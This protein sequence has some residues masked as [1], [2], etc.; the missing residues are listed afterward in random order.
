MQWFLVNSGGCIFEGQ[1]DQ[2][3]TQIPSKHLYGAS[4]GQV[5]TGH[6]SPTEVSMQ[7]PLEHLNLPLWHP[8]IFGQFSK[9]T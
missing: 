6:I 7:S 3:I 4:L 9:S 5:L 2:V 8:I 1:K